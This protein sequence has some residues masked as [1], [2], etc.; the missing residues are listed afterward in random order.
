MFDGKPFCEYHYHEANNSLCASPRC[1]LPIEGQCAVAHNGDRYHR[2]HFIC[3]HTSGG[4]C[5]EQLDDEYWEIDGLKLCDRHAKIH[6]LFPDRLEDD[7]EDGEG[8][9]GW[10]GRLYDDN[11]TDEIR[12]SLG[13]LSSYDASKYGRAQ[14]R[15]TRYIDL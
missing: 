15:M 12:D 14:K 4:V 3:E 9:K 5:K 10:R 13:S 8:G 2:E 7:D 6:P 11:D 1:G